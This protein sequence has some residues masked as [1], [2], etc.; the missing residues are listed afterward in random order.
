MKIAILLPLKETFTE[1][2]SGAVSI[3]VNT[4]LSKSIFK[5]DTKIYGTAVKKPLNKNFFI[6]L[7]SNKI[8]F[9]NSSYVRSFIHKM[10][11]STTIIELHNRPRYFTELKKKFPY[12]KFILF[13]HNNPEDLI[14]SSS[15]KEREVIYNTCDKIIFLSHWIKIQF[16]KGLKISNTK[17]FDIFY[18]GVKK[19]KKFPSNKKN[20]IVFVGK[21]NKSKGYDIFI[22]AVSKFINKNKSWN[23]IAIGS[24]PRREIKKNTNIEE[25][26]DV[27]NSRVL[28]ILQDS[29]VSVANSQWEEPLGRLPIESASR[30]CFPIVSS[31]GGLTETI[32][33]EFSILKKNTDNELLK[34]LIFFNKNSKKLLKL[35]KKVFK[36]FSLDLSKTTKH[37][38]DI[39]SEFQLTLKKKYNLKKIKIL[40]IASF[41]ETSNA[42]LYYSTA[43]KFNNGFIRIGHFVQTLD[44]KDFLRKNLINGTNKLNIKI[45]NIC[46]NLLP[47]LIVIGHTDKIYDKTLREI[48]NLLPEIKIIRWYLDSVSSEFLEKNKKILFSN[49]R[50]LDQTFVTSGITT[51]LTKFKNKIH[52][53]PNPVDQSIEINKNFLKTN[54]PYDLFFALS[55]GQHRKGLKF[56]K[57]DER[58]TLIDYLH[59]NLPFLRKFFISSNFN[60]PKWGAEFYHYIENSKMGLNI[61]RGKS[62]NLYSS[63]RIATLVGNGLLTFMDIKTKYMKFFTNKEIIFFKNNK[64]LVKKILFFKK[65]EKLAVQY[66]KNAYNKY[67]K[68]FNSEIVCSFMLSKVGYSNKKNFFWTK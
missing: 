20:T 64:D 35:Q 34:K 13:F 53:I 28:E 56:G 24:E 19:I 15:I 51:S 54:L 27:P 66:A 41:N 68:H 33:N 8:I 9:S 1:V 62:Q 25:L 22:K 59:I 18:P 14:G 52:F 44:D 38:D 61:S 3:L 23:A 17:N 39:R 36:E 57:T 63:D 26:G 16:F 31:S 67:H 58:D 48:Y 29:K 47:N 30:G 65:N 11:K 60:T 49:I 4:H 12:K 2:G 10:D 40:H 21:L 50:Y 43:N 5:N 45:L 46:K 42:D 7:T 32:S 37:L 6:P 55:H